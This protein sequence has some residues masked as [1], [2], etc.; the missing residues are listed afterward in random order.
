MWRF[1]I[2]TILVFCVTAWCGL[3]LF[4]LVTAAEHG[5]GGLKPGLLHVAGFTNQFGASSGTLVIIRL[6][7]L[8]LI[9]VLVAFIR[10][11]RHPKL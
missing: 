10:R 7:A 9:T 5:L 2:N 8:L 6:A 4:I 1:V 11:V 3:M